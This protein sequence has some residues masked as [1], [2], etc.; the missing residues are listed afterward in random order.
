MIFVM[1]Q[2]D[3]MIMLSISL[4]V[5]LIISLSVCIYGILK[6]PSPEPENTDWQRVWR[7]LGETLKRRALLVSWNFTPE[8]L[9]DPQNINS[10]LRQECCSSGRSEVAQI[11]WG[12][13]YV[14]QALLSTNSERVGR[15]SE[16]QGRLSRREYEL[17][18][19][20]SKLSGRVWERVQTRPEP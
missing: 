5:F 6:K 19:K 14:Y 15:V 9:Q 12:L 10:Y 8:H 18:E 7:D 11:I 2:H 1:S 20:V 17:R 4:N 16:S 3:S 13:A